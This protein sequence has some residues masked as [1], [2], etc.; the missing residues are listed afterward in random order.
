MPRR[1]LILTLLAL[2]ALPASAEAGNTRAVWATVNICDT[3]AHPDSVG[4]RASM[5]GNRSRQTMHMRFSAQ[6][7]RSDGRW[8]RIGGNAVSPWRSVGR[9]SRFTTREYGFTFKFDPPAAGRTFTVRGVVN[10]QWRVRK[11]R[12]GRV[13]SVVV[14][15]ERA[16]TEAQEQPVDQ[17]DPEGFSAASCEL[18]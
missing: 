1:T 13:R 14:R 2:V 9:A 6:Y 16:I 10:F 5:P 3:E 4:V 12:N 17:S 11:K 15:R 8:G 7:L 18:R